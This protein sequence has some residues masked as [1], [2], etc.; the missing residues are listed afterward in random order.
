MDN[1]FEQLKRLICKAITNDYNCQNV[2]NY[3]SFYKN[4]EDDYG[5]E[6]YEIHTDTGNSNLRIEEKK[7]LFENLNKISI[8]YLNLP[9]KFYKFGLYY[10]ITLQDIEIMNF[11]VENDEFIYTFTTTHSHKENIKIFLTY[12]FCNEISEITGYVDL[13]DDRIRKH[14]LTL[15]ARKVGLSQSW[16]VDNN[17]VTLQSSVSNRNHNLFTRVQDRRERVRYVE[18]RIDTDIKQIYCP[19][20][21]KILGWWNTICTLEF[22]FP[23]GTFYIR[24]KGLSDFDYDYNVFQRLRERNP[25]I[26]TIQFED[27]QCEYYD[28]EHKYIFNCFIYLFGYNNISLSLTQPPS[29]ESDDSSESDNVIMIANPHLLNAQNHLK[30]S[31][32]KRYKSYW[33]RGNG[34]FCNTAKLRA[35][36]YVRSGC[37]T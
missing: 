36:P 1:E 9:L 2:D 29:S 34:V 10:R 26:G 8:T 13:N 25:R 11:F 3:F 35:W 5:L 30:D 21:G 12:F 20:L 37:R 16:D 6:I 17:K 19:N 33:N 15:A 32:F 31:F 14:V 22:H 23:E 28:E 4:R 24:K 7:I 18:P 27:G